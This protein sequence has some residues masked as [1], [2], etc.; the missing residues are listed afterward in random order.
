MNNHPTKTIVLLELIGTLVFI[1]VILIAFCIYLYN[2]RRNSGIR[3]SEKELES[4]Y[5]K[6]NTKK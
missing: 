3:S 4:T 1:L 2:S 5:F 6:I